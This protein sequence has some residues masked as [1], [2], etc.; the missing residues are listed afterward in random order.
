MIDDINESLNQGYL[1]NEQ[2]QIVFARL[3]QKLTYRQLV[4]IFK[5]SY[6]NVLFHCLKRTCLL[7]YWA[8]GMLGDG[9]EYLSMID[10]DTF[11][12]IISQAAEE[13]NCIPAM[14]AVSL[15]YYLK[16]KKKEF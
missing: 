2:V 16:K 10:M 9:T 11:E 13:N 5:L 15:A 3:N 12:N 6:Q 1:S 7:Q 14:Y 4:D 8:S